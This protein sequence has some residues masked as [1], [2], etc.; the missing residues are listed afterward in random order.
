MFGIN[1][2]Q[3][4]WGTLFGR[5]FLLPLFTVLRP[6]RGGALFIRQN[7]PLPGGYI[8]REAVLFWES[9]LW[10]GEGLGRTLRSYG[11]GGGGGQGFSTLGF[12]LNFF[13]NASDFFYTPISVSPPPPSPLGGGGPWRE[14]PERPTS[15]WLKEA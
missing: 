4:R 1:R 7:C 11:G 15:G 2:S 14:Y 8:I 3:D 9:F 12:H 10:G 13:E 5:H 6:S